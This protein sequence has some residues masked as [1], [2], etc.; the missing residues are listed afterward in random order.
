MHG[1]PPFSTALKY[2]LILLPTR[3]FDY[4]TEVLRICLSIPV[5]SFV[6][7]PSCLSSVYKYR[8]CILRVLYC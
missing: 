5:C 7:F 1:V 4:M 6:L 8:Y 2:S 3:T